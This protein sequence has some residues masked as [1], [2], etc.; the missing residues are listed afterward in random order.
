[1]FAHHL[2]L[3]TV[4]VLISRPKIATPIAAE[5][6]M[7]DLVSR[8]YEHEIRV[9][10]ISQNQGGKSPSAGYRLAMAATT[11]MPLLLVQR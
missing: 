11:A 7:S 8:V 3:G 4:V 9:S 2:P 1:M 5:V 6:Q 10:G